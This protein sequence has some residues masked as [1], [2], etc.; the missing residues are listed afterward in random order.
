MK[1]TIRR[2]ILLKALDYASVSREFRDGILE[3]FRNA[4][5]EY[6]AKSG[7]EVNVGF[8]TRF[9]LRGSK[10]IPA[11]DNARK[12]ILR[13][14]FREAGKYLGEAI[15]YLYIIVLSQV[16]I[17]ELNEKKILSHIK[18]LKPSYDDDPKE[19]PVRFISHLKSIDTS[20]LE[21]AISGLAD[22]TL[23]MIE[24]TFVPL[25]RKELEAQYKRERNLHY[26]LY[27]PLA[28]FLAG[29]ILYISI[30]FESPILSF[31]APLAGIVIL[32]M[33]RKYFRLKRMLEWGSR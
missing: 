25:N 32:Q 10:V 22:L 2:A 30:L 28:I 27:L 21:K 17:D 14:K 19:L 15:Y 20:S 5:K 16:T 11:L 3:G 8:L 13:R 7:D 29:V 23:Y 4:Y 12:Y 33:Y 6:G 1:I 31:L 24:G 18:S 9:R 26:F